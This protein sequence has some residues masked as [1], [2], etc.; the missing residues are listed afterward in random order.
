[1]EKE[2]KNLLK[3]NKLFIG[4]SAGTSKKGNEYCMVQFLE[5][6]RFNK[7]EVLT[8]SCLDDKLPEGIENLKCGDMVD[9]LVEI[10][11]MAKPPILVKIIQ[12]TA[13]SVLI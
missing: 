2:Q 3:F 7:G 1:M 6:N 9:I 5:I 11:S 8:L 4:A 10:E 13:D 12:K